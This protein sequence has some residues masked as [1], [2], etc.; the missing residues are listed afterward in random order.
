MKKENLYQLFEIEYYESEEYKRSKYVSSFFELIFIVSGSGTQT[1]NGNTFEYREGN[2]FLITPEDDHSFQIRTTTGFLIIRFNDVYIGSNMSSIEH[3]RHMEYILWNANHKPGCILINLEDKRLVRPLMEAII[4]EHA[5]RDFFDV[6]LLRQLVNTVIV[7]VARC[8]ARSFPDKMGSDS[9]KKILDIIR[10]IQSNIRYPEKIKAANIA[11]HFA[12]SEFYMGRYFKKH[13]G[14][15][16]QQYILSFK[17]KLVEARL[18]Y[19]DMRINEIVSELGFTD[20][21]H[22]NKL[23]RKFKGVSPT[24]YRKSKKNTNK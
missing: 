22:I 5:N 8:V 16:M 2:M 24:E 9:E 12:I 6:E 3:I 17:L 20:E 19:S 4:R 15:T 10:Y 13:T 21:S 7:I 18:L 23:F 1:L 11:G 14:E